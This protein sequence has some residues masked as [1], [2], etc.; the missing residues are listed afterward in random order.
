MAINPNFLIGLMSDRL[1]QDKN[2]VAFEAQQRAA[3]ADRQKFV[4]REAIKAN[5]QRESQDR[6]QGLKKEFATFKNDQQRQNKVFDLQ[7][8]ANIAGI[9]IESQLQDFSPEEV[10]AFTSSVDQALLDAGVAPENLPSLRFNE[11]IRLIGQV[12]PALSKGLGEAVLGNIKQAKLT[13]L[14]IDKVYSEVVKRIG[15]LPDEQEAEVRATADAARAS[16]DIFEL[17]RLIDD[18]K[19]DIGTVEFARRKTVALLV[20]L[21]RKD[22]KF[23]DIIR[24]FKLESVRLNTKDRM[25]TN[26]RIAVALQRSFNEKISV[27]EAKSKKFGDLGDE[28]TGRLKSLR[29]QRVVLQEITG[30]A[31]EDIRKEGI[32]RRGRIVREAAVG[33]DPTPTEAPE[34]LAPSISSSE[35]QRIKSAARRAIA[36][37]KGKGRSAGLKAR[38]DFR[39]S[40]ESIINLLSKDDLQQIE[41]ILNE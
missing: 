8:K 27:L 37:S 17:Q 39:D 4:E 13:K 5:I 10:R 28:D 24:K 21:D 18:I 40:L 38:K 7:N 9:D 3:E 25:N 1:E 22:I 36:A 11:K 16:G 35:V 32:D 15:G 14:R 30:R 20:A 6:A 41:S 12:D 31:N 2:R 19:E 33:A 23:D 34:P 26:D 29:D